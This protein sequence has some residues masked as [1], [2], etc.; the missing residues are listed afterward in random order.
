MIIKIIFYQEI[1]MKYG[2]TPFE[3]IIFAMM[4]SVEH[5]DVSRIKEYKMNSLNSIISSRNNY[6]FED[7]Y[8]EYYEDVDDMLSESNANFF[9]DSYVDSDRFTCYG[10]LDDDDLSDYDKL[11]K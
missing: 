8:D 2:S 6:Y 4:L 11:L 10:I 1:I 7:T 3:E 9:D 5:T